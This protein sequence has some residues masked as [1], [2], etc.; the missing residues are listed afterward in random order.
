M[1]DQPICTVRV[2]TSAFQSGNGLRIQKDIYVLRKQ[3]SG[4]D[5]FNEDIQMAGAADTVL[6]I[7]NLNECKDGVY[8]VM[9]TDAKRDLE[10]GIIEDYKFNLIPA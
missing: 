10:T 1:N 7:K 3:S 8:R 4:H 6:I 5:F 2:R 9:I